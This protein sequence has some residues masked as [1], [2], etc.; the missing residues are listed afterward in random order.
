[1]GFFGEIGD[2]V[3]VEFAAWHFEDG[4]VAFDAEEGGGDGFAGFVGPFAFNGFGATGEEGIVFRV[5]FGDGGVVAGDDGA[6]IDPFAEGFDFVGG[7]GFAFSGRGH[8]IVFLIGGDGDEEVAFFG[9]AG[10]DDVTD[11]TGNSIWVES[12]AGFGFAVAV[13]F[14]ALGFEDGEDL[15]FVVDGASGGR[16]EE[17]RGEACGDEQDGEIWN[18]FHGGREGCEQKE[19][20]FRVRWLQVMRL[21]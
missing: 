15:G 3:V 6:G 14:V 20:R 16:E 1:L 10:D 2:G 19:Y 11:F 17:G 4:F 8:E 7:E 9:I 18:R 21:K 12:D 5:I 13:A